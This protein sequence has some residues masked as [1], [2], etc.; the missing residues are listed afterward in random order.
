MIQIQY[1][2]IVLYHLST[3]IPSKDIF[4]DDND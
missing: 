2:A 1:F 4:I 3:L